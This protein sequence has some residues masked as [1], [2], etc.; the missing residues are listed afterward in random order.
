[1][2]SRQGMYTSTPQQG[3]TLVEVLVALSVMALLALMSWRAL[4]GMQH[5]QTQTRTRSDQLITLQA[6]L[7]QWN[8]DLDALAE[9]G[10][11]PALNFD[12]R[13]L[14]L[15]R[16]DPLESQKADVG[17]QVVAWAIHQGRWTRWVTGN[18]RTRTALLQAWE[19]AARWGQTPI[20]ADAAFQVVLMPVQ[21]WQIF[22][23]RSDAWTNPLSADDA[24]LS[25]SDNAGAAPNSGTQAP[26]LPA[27]PDGVRLV[28]DLGEG[29]VL[30]GPLV[31]DWVRPV[32]G[33]SKS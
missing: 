23:Y 32:L 3:F 5:V 7:G 30:N 29:Q 26:A 13:S 24:A 20:E 21:N 33:G 25:R 2:E 11:V 27:M 4:D 16:R 9:T 8:A 17:L 6:S 10:V 1:M 14:R 22:Y 19:S 18:L 31:K 15:T 28:L 12:G